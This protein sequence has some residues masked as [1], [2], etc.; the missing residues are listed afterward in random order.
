[1]PDK[2]KELKNMLDAWKNEV[3]AEEPVIPENKKPAGG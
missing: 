2:V 1:M 3:N